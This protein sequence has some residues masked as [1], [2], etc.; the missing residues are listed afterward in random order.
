M[1]AASELQGSGDLTKTGLGTLSLS[2]G[3]SNFAAFTGQVFVNAGLVT[4]GAGGSNSLGTATNGTFIA[5]GAAVD[6]AGQTGAVAEP[7]N[8]KGTG[9]A[10]LPAGALTNSN[11]TALT[12]TGAITL[13]ASASIGGV[14]NL[15][16]TTGITDGGQGFA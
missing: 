2:N 15:T 14:G 11:P 7:F 12:L 13:G 8:I 3:S 16:I 10:A 9:L 5:S 6:F 1:T 4:F